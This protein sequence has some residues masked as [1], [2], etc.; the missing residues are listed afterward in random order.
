MGENTEHHLAVYFSDLKVEMEKFPPP[1]VFLSGNIVG[2]AVR[3]TVLAT[4]SSLATVQTNRNCKSSNR[5][6]GVSAVMK[7]KQIE[8]T[9]R[10]KQDTRVLPKCF[11]SSLF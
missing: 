6:S 11:F 8:K 2:A 4:A 9:N 7:S 10:E 5:N 1:Q 3:K